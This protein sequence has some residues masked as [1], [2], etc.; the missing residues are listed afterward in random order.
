MKKQNSL[1]VSVHQGV[2]AIELMIVLVIIMLAAIYAYPRYTQYMEEM[3]W[4]VE[5]S[6]MTTVGSAAKSY[7]RDNRDTL[8]S[9]VTG[10]TPVTVTAAKL[11]QEGYLPIG[12]SLQNIAA[13]TYLV[14]IARDPTFNQKLVAFVL[15]EGGQTFSYKALRYIAL[16]I[17]GSGGYVWTD[18]IAV[19]AVGGW[20]K[21][22]TTFGLAAESGR[23]LTWL[24][25]DVLGTDTQESD[26]LYRYEVSGRPDLNRMH[27]HID[28]NKNN[29][30]NVKDIN[31]ETG[32]FSETVTAE[33]DIKSNTGWLITQSG[34]GWLNEEHG[35]GF[36]MNDNDWIRTVNNKGIYTGGQLRGGSV[37]AEGRLGTDEFLQLNKVMTAGQACEIGTL[38]R[39]AEGAPLF[40][41]KGIWTSIGGGGMSRAGVNNVDVV[42]NGSYK[43]LLVTVSSLFNPADGSHTGSAD[44]NVYVDGGLVGIVSTRVQVDKSGS[45][46]H[47]WGYQNFGVAQKQLVV[48]VK[49]NSRITV[50]LANSAYHNTSDV[51]IDL[52]S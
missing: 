42:S 26:R 25:S 41:Q 44:F 12:F 3:E 17:E 10:G 22:L 16:K 1:P 31:A 9:Q 39:D 4:G 38:T 47:Y 14:A 30:N 29:L 2:L 45:N 49:S 7:I 8:V 20:E 33:G 46:G 24:S 51:R 48:N 6:N 18:N 5:A 13:Q 28:L 23:P 15:T 21:N 19:G 40:C 32:T 36:Y 11:Q 52:T 35:G 37:H 50:T 34:K 27:T 43:V